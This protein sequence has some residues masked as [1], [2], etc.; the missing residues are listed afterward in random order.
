GE[1]LRDPGEVVGDDLA[2]GDLHDR[3]DGDPPRVVGVAGEVRLLEP[4]DAQDG[5]PAVRVEVERPRADVV[6][7]AGQPDGQ[8][9]LEPQEPP[10]DEGAVGPGAGPRGDETV[11]PGL[12]GPRPGPL[13]HVGACGV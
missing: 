2:A 10:D 7:G 5:V 6:D 11:A 4:L 3:R 1:V 13:G 8:G 12:D 9:V